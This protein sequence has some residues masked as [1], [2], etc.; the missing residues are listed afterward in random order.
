MALIPLEERKIVPQTLD[1]VPS[2]Y[3]NQR[4]KLAWPVSELVRDLEKDARNAGF[5]APQ[6]QIISGYRSIASQERLWKEAL[7]KADGDETLARQT[8]SPPGNSSHHSGFAFD[9]FLGIGGTKMERAPSQFKSKEYK[10][11][12]DVLAPK[13][14]LTQL[15]NEPWHWECDK[16]CRDFYLLNKYGTS[17]YTPPQNEVDRMGLL[18]SEEEF[19]SGSQTS[20]KGKYVLLAS[21]GAL[22]CVGV[23]AYMSRNKN[24]NTL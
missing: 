14:N 10:F 19:A 5:K 21:V 1:L 24:S 6:F 22:A 12:R 23:W 4:P 16:A 15:P 3:E 17:E 20:N 13:Y 9:I 7:I 2:A 18:S 11:M 8:T